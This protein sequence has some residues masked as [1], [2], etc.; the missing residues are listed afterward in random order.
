LKGAW[1]AMT[2]ELCFRGIIFLI[3]L[4]HKTKKGNHY[5]T[6]TQRKLDYEE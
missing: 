4:Y 2:A 3:R 1:I 6:E 5:E